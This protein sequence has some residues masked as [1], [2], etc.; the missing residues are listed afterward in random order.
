[1]P[2][3]SLNIS[4]RVL[5][6]FIATEAMSAPE[7]NTSVKLETSEHYTDE[8]WGTYTHTRVRRKRDN[9]NKLWHIVLKLPGKFLAKREQ[10]KFLDGRFSFQG[11]SST[12]PCEESYTVCVIGKQTVIRESLKWL[13]LDWKRSF[14]SIRW[15]SEF[16]FSSPY[17]ERSTK[18]CVKNTASAATVMTKVARM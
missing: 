16:L 15:H 13:A 11:L 6:Q 5:G 7:S 18:N 12:Q 10:V 1:M 2:D 14:I 8:V 4:R 9:L 17:S 3:D